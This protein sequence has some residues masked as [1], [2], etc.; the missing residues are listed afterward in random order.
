MQSSSM[1]RKCVLKESLDV[2]WYDLKPWTLLPSS[3]Q[4]GELTEVS[5]GTF[6]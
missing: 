4:Y 1:M 5:W 6:M 2:V 3:I